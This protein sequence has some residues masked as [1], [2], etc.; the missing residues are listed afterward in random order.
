MKNDTLN[1]LSILLALSSGLMW[2][3]STVGTSKAELS[4]ITAF[5]NSSAAILAVASAV[6]S[7]ISLF[8]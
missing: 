7:L 2:H 5:E 1:S 4:G 3:L 8:K 6:C